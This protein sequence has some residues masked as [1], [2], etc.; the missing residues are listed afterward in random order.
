MI[1]HEKLLPF[2][3]PYGCL[4]GVLSCGE[5]NTTGLTNTFYPAH[6]FKMVI[7]RSKEEL[8]HIDHVNRHKKYAKFQGIGKRF[9]DGSGNAKLIHW[10]IKNP[11]KSDD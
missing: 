7:A 11:L 3:V 1:G 8:A 6:L 10:G 2:A 4:K 9:P 5:I